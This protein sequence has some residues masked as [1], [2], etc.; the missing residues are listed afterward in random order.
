MDSIL[1]S[2]YGKKIHVRLFDL[3][4]DEQE[5]ICYKPCKVTAY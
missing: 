2:H 3:S 5:N 4:L 1:N